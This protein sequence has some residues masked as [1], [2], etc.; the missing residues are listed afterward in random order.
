MLYLIHYR[1]HK[2]KQNIELVPIFN[3]YSL[4]VDEDRWKFPNPPPKKAIC[5]K[6][7]FL[8]RLLS[9]SSAPLNL[10]S[11][12]SFS[13][14]CVA[15]CGHGHGLALRF[16]LLLTYHSNL[17]PQHPVFIIEVFTPVLQPVT[18]AF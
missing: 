15:L 5:E 17:P 14:L 6:V 18:R 12:A 7:A 2:L 11:P 9:P 4:S 13:F 3:S 16:H 8:S 10:A 1:C